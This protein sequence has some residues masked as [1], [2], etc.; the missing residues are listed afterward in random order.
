MM[1][2]V[3]A[4]KGDWVAAS[5]MVKGPARGDELAEFGVGGGEVRDGGGES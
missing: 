5:F 3:R 1:A 4:S 2:S